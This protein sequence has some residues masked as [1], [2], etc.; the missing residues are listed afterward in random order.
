MVLA[1]QGTSEYNMAA[2]H[3]MRPDGIPTVGI[4]VADARRGICIGVGEAGQ[5]NIVHQYKITGEVVAD[6]AQV[7]GVINTVWI[8]DRIIGQGGQLR[9]YSFLVNP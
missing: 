1:V 7:V 3:I 5:G 2:I 9:S 6:I 8:S 4:I